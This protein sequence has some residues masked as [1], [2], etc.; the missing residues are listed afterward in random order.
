M[1]H[2]GA[3]L[4]RCWSVLL[5]NGFDGGLVTRCGL[6]AELT[7]ASAYFLRI[8]SGGV[9]AIVEQSRLIICDCV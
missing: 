5:R 3:S 4:R 6:D 2:S 9:E 7:E 8:S 1:D